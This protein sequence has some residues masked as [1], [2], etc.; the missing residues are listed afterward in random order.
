MYKYFAKLDKTGF[1][2]EYLDDAHVIFSKFNDI[3]ENYNIL[4]KEAF[5]YLEEKG[6]TDLILMH[7]LNRVASYPNSISYIK[8]FRQTEYDLPLP[9]G[10]VES[11]NGNAKLVKTFVDDYVSRGYKI[12]FCVNNHH[13]IKCIQD[14]MAEWEYKLNYMKLDISK[15]LWWLRW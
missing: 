10:E 9:I 4:V 12:V 7:D 11:A 1:L 15:L 2:F 8:D 5:E 14:W 6:Q 3:K 13:Q